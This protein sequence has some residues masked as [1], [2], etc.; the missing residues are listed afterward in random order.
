M[1]ELAKRF[2]RTTSRIESIVLLA[3]VLTRIDSLPDSMED[4]FLQAGSDVMESCF[5]SMPEEVKEAYEIGDHSEFLD[6][7]FENN[8]F[9]F[10]VKFATPVIVPLPSGPHFSWGC[11]STKWVYGTTFDAALEAGFNW[12]KK[13]RTKEL[14]S[15]EDL[16]SKYAKSVDIEIV[17]DE[18]GKEVL[19][20]CCKLG[21]WGVSG[22]SKEWVRR[23]AFHY[24]Q[25][26]YSDGEYN[27]L[28]KE[29]L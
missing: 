16:D 3:S 9:G 6:W 2:H 27:D 12:V 4:D 13:C 18:F 11:Y 7:L 14:A 20:I 22:S 19:K 8:H 1:K 5:G 24:W 25:Q 26:Y 21:L 23:E 28:L 15:N 29:C 10:L 17:T